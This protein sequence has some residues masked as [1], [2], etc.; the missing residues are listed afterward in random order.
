MF[1][2]HYIVLIIMSLCLC[3]SVAVLQKLIAPD[4]NE[5]IPIQEEKY[6]VPNEVQANDVHR[7]RYGGIPEQGYQEQRYDS[8]PEQRYGGIPEQ[9]YGGVPE[10]RYQEQRQMFG[11]GIQEQRYGG[12]QEQ[13]NGGVQDQRNGACLCVCCVCLSTSVCLSVCPCDVRVYIHGACR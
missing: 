12:A 7:Q 6:V 8:I 9:R 10:Q 5:V 3:R 13:I 4:T 2:V 1:S 11:G